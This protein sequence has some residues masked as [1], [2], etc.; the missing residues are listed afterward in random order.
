M[1]IKNIR[2]LILV[3]IFFI[4]FYFLVIGNDKRNLSKKM[5]EEY[6]I[7]LPIKEF[8]YD[9]KF[10]TP[11]SMEQK[12]K[13]KNN[14]YKSKYI[15]LS[16]YYNILSNGNIKEE[17]LYKLFELYL[18]ND[19]IRDNRMGNN[20]EEI[21]KIIDEIVLKIENKTGIELK[22]EKNKNNTIEILII[23]HDIDR[24]KNLT[25]YY[26]DCY[27][28]LDKS[29]KKIEK[30]HCENLN[31]KDIENKLWK[32]T[33]KYFFEEKKSKYIPKK[34]RYD[35]LNFKNFIYDNNIYPVLYVFIKLDKEANEK[36]ILEIIKNGSYM[37]K[38]RKN[39]NNKTMATIFYIY[40]E[41][42]NIDNKKILY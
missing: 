36:E 37:E 11:L 21:E 24:D 23:N 38:I 6:N 20:Y 41:D 34:T 12:F 9:E 40:Y 1:K 27:K 13:F 10:I 31:N 2:I 15:N 28:I 16:Y 26:G 4:L 42:D 5:E 18:I 7:I 32:Q 35:K 3:I 29:L 33:S 19:Y 25:Y 30:T 17:L 8:E 22:N 39:Y 14:I